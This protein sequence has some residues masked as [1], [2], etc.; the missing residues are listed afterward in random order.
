MPA[1]VAFQAWE[2]ARAE[3]PV[4]QL[5]YLSGLPNHLFQKGGG[6]RSALS[7]QLGFLCK[8][9]GYGLGADAIP[10]VSQSLTPLQ[11]SGLKLFPF[12]KWGG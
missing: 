4:L 8:N 1:V 6:V 5:A 2:H 9:E 3:R 10:T 12:L 11:I 7:Q